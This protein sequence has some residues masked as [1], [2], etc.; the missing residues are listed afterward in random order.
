MNPI[1]KAGQLFIITVESD[2]LDDNLKHSIDH[3]NIGGLILFQR[4]LTSL[5]RTI[6]FIRDVQAYAKKAGRPPLWISIDQEGGGISYL[7][8]EMAVSPG[9]MN[10]A[11]GPNAEAHAEKAYSIMAAQ[12]NAIG[13]NMNYAP[14]LDVNNNPD[15]P[16]IGTRAFSEDVDEVSRLSAIAA[17]AQQKEGILACGKHFPGHGDTTVDSHLSLPVLS[18]TMDDMYNLELKPFIHAFNHGMKAV[19]TAHIVFSTIDPDR[20]AT[21]SPAI[22]KGILRDK[23]SYDGLIITDSMEMEAIASFYGK[24]TGTKM[25]LEAGVN[26]ILACGRNYPAQWAMIEAAAK[27]MNNETI[28]QNINDSL[29]LQH[30][31]KEAWIDTSFPLSEKEVIEKCH[32]PSAHEK[33]TAIAADGITVLQNPKQLLTDAWRHTLLISQTSFNDENYQGERTNPAID[34]PVFK[35]MTQVFTRSEVPDASEKDTV[36][37]QLTHHD[38]VIILLNTRRHLEEE[39]EAFIREIHEQNQ[40]IVVVSLWNPQLFRNLKTLD[41][42]TMVATYSNTSHTIHALSDILCGKKQAIGQLPVTVDL[43]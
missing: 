20:P 25:A 16:V 14:L 15:N 2:E 31:F 29:A 28:M 12:L 5:Q 21:L 17:N 24:E 41:G 37:K 34:A 8:K 43:R 13:F 32:A 23:L 18:K 42:L 7:F 3:Y 9:N 6:R 1:E 35:D 39:W 36:L 40:H 22:L 10:L 33:M 38:R 19:M 4:N 27:A 26:I 30:Q 11:A